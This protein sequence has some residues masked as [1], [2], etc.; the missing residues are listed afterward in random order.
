MRRPLCTVCLL[1]AVFVFFSV[2]LCPPRQADL[3]GYE[4]KTVCLAGR[5]YQKE[6]RNAAFGSGNL[7]IYLDQIAVSGKTFSRIEEEDERNTVSIV[8]SEYE[9]ENV[10]YQDK[11]QGVVCYMEEDAGVKLGSTV[12]VAG[13][14]QEFMP[15]SNPGEFDSREYYRI[16]KLDFKLKNARLIQSSE[17]YD[18]FYE[19]CYKIRT[20]CAKILDECFDGEDAGIMKAVLLGD[21]SGL[22]EELKELYK[23]NGIMHIMAISGLHISFLG[24]GIYRILQY[25]RLPGA[26]AGILSAVVIWGYGNMT[27]MSVSARRAVL[28]FGIKLLAD[29]LGRTYDMLTALSLSAAL[30]LAEQPLYVRHSGFL[31]S[32]GAI[33]GISIVLPFLEE[34]FWCKDRRRLWEE[35]KKQDS[36]YKKGILLAKERLQKGILSG[37][38]IFLVTFPIQIYYY[39]QY[40]VYSVF[41]NLFIVPLMTFVMLS[42]ITTVFLGTVQI[43]FSWNAVGILQ[44]MVAAAGHWILK[45]YAFSCEG[46]QTLPG[47]VWITGRPGNVRMAFYY[48]GL[49]TLLLAGWIQKE[50]GIKMIALRTLK[51]RPFRKLPAIKEAGKK[52][53]RM[54]CVILLALGTG[55]LGVRTEK[56]LEITFLDVGQ[57][58]C[59]YIRTDSGGRYLIDGGSTSK[60][61]VGKYQITPFLKSKGAGSLEMVFVSHGDKDHYSGIEELLE[62][63]AADRIRIGCL[64]LP[65]EGCEKL[66]QLAHKQGIRVVHMQAGDKITSGM[67]GMECLNP[68]G[69]T[70]DV[71]EETGREKTAGME[72]K[73]EQ[74]QVLYLT[75]KEFSALFTGD[76]TGDNEKKMQK[77]LEE[78][79]GDHPLTV[80]KVAHHGSKHS[81]D[82]A[83]LKETAPVISVISSG[84]KNSYGHPHKELTDRLEN[85]G[86]KI[87]RTAEGGAV[88]IWTDGKTVEVQSFRQ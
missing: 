6:Y 57:G 22:G 15:A 5:V 64:V 10:R 14:L 49:C 58:D 54:L 50:Y 16:L 52:G 60:S 88:T 17:K 75:Y 36:L 51:I 55:Q 41:L 44:G 19:Q 73:N 43:F 20:F 30:L 7:L 23:R 8:G 80:L 85:S 65:Q 21:K 87:C 35:H 72:D 76:I 68:A 77:R 25:L 39:Y 18:R 38:A 86:T 3:G 63:T 32:F 84:R 31:L 83:F 53:I 33:A 24:L 82:E 45:F 13:E 27:G 37:A 4:G 2:L 46:A 62:N 78:I 71:S 48:G 70:T 56:G 26:A 42:G 28:M 79:R 47:A 12:V 69:K 66:A 67:T 29:M 74:S 1:F 59:I 11:I 61:Q 81:T 40:S 9:K 34:V